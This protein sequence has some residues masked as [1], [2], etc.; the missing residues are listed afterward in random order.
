M[1]GDND[2]INPTIFVFK[3]HNDLHLVFYSVLY[4]KKY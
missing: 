3:K 4:Y 2:M 1:I